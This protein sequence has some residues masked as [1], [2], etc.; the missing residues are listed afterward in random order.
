MKDYE[1]F[2]NKEGVCYIREATYFDEDDTEYTYLDLLYECRYNEELVIK[3]FD[4][5]EWS[6]PSTLLLEWVGD[7]EIDGDFNI[8][9]QE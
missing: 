9:K 7:G 6:H 3:L 2:K 5:L 4:Q 8:I 1:A